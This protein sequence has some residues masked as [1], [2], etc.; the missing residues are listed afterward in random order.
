M[1]V[2]GGSGAPCGAS[3]SL[4][5]SNRTVRAEE[6]GYDVLAQAAAWQRRRPLPPSPS[7][8]AEPA[9]ALCSQPPLYPGQSLQPWWTATRPHVARIELRSARMHRFA[10][11]LATL[12]PV[13]PP[14]CG[15]TG[16]GGGRARRDV[17]VERRASSYWLPPWTWTRR[18]LGTAFAS[19][20]LFT[21][22]RSDGTAD[23]LDSTAAAWR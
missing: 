11:C 13:P 16:P 5:A 9:Y 17:R 22:W 8:S 20:Q 7:P 14:G 15:C 23:P 10:N 18:G 6:G 19:H 1:A 12:P 2:A 4:S 21:L 3:P